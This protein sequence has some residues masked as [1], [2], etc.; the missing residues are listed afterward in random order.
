MKKHITP[1]TA[2]ALCL[3][4]AVAA[5]NVTVLACRV[6]FNRAMPTASAQ[7]LYGKLGEIEQLVQD[8][9]VGEFDEQKAVET[10]ATG[11][12]VGVGDRWS[13]YL[14]K[15][16]YDAYKLDFAGKL[17]GIGVSVSYSRTTGE[18]RITD[19]YDGSPAEQAGLQKGDLLL[20]AGDKTVEKD[21]YNAVVGA[22]H[23]EEGTEA[24][25]RVRHAESGETETLRIRRAKVDKTAVRGRMLEG[26]TGLIT[27]R[28]FDGGADKQFQAVLD[29]LLARGA[30]KLIF[31]VRFNPGGSVPVL[32]NILDPLLPEGDIIRLEPKEGEGKTYTSDA[33]A[34]DLPMAV[35]VNAES[36]SAAEFFPAALQEYGKAVVVGDQT[37]GKGYSQRQYV[38]SDGSALILSDQKYYTPHGKNLAG[39]GITPD[40]KVSLSDEAYQNYYFLT[41]EEDTQLQAAISALAAIDD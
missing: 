38:L 19:V 24:T 11:F 35:L 40:V 36:I 4:S 8:K 10:A 16:Q 34:L 2:A 17:V 15:E 1:G 27:I 6:E 23:G 30:E 22:V 3:L 41:D 20:G 9:Y 18:T 25:V 14:S 39:I 33:A 28:D 13:N 21:G 37:I 26:K 29:D 7:R 5:C 31:D 12:V 32:A